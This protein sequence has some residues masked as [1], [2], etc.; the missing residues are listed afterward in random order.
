MV[1]RDFE[2]HELHYNHYKGLNKERCIIFRARVVEYTAN[3]R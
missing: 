3:A 1:E 2:Q